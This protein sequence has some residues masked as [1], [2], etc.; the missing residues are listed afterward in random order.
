M[1]SPGYA[2][3]E[4][5]IGRCA[6]AWSAAGI[7][8]VQLPERHAAATV[9]RLRRRN[10]GLELREPPA[11]VRRAIAAIQRLLDGAGAELSGIALDLSGVSPFQRRVYQAARAIPAGRTVSYGALAAQL[12]QPGAARAIGRAMGSNPV[13]II[14]PCHRVLAAGGKAGGFSAHGGVA[15]KF[16]LL[17]A[18]GTALQDWSAGP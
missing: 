11:P 12:G 13:P 16:A 9:A 8:A 2:L 18:E 7:V 15:T 1:T 14:V 6:V 3:F 4:T 17:R 5:P 10:P